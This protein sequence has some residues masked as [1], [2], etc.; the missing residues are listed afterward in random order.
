MRA[1]TAGATRAAA[2]SPSQ[3]AASAATSPAREPAQAD[4]LGA[5]VAP[6]VGEDAGERRPAADLGVAIGAEDQHG[7][8]ARAAQHEAE[9]EERR[10]VG[11][12][13]VVEHQH[14]RAVLGQAREHVV[15]GGEQPVTCARIVRGRAARLAEEAVE[16]ARARAG[17]R[18]GRLRADVAQHLGEGLE[19]RQ[20]VLRAAAEQDGRAAVQR[21]PGEAQ[22]EAR[23]ADAR[24]ARQ[25]HEAAG[26]VGGDA[27]PG[28]REPRPLRA[29]AH[30]GILARTCEDG[31]RRDVR[32]RRR[33][34]RG[35]EPGQALLGAHEQRVQRGGGP[36]PA[37]GLGQV[38]GRLGR[39]RQPVERLGA[40]LGVGAP[41]LV[42]PLVVHVGQQDAVAGRVRPVDEAGGEQVGALAQVDARAVERDALARGHQAGGLGAERAAQLRQGRAQ[43]RAGALVEHLGP[44]PRR[45]RA[46]GVRS[47]VGG[48][49]GEQRA[50]A[51]GPRRR[52]LPA[53][54]LEPQ[55]P[56][57]ADA[58]HR[59]PP[60]P[61]PGRPAAGPDPH[62]GAVT[63]A[64]PR[65]AGAGAGAP[66]TG[67][68]ADHGRFTVA[69]RCPSGRG[70]HSGA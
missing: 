52:E 20:R 37:G 41:E 45:E 36:R 46:A 4:P 63:P 6:Q 29:A 61:R 51:A 66:A 62:H 23:L 26:P 8:R 10:P 47:R 22:R 25:E 3:V 57:E 33:A 59:R 7:R 30:E 55:A 32:R 42:H 12:V 9:Q 1:C 44:E 60:Y 40:A 11:P 65:A 31:R 50:G 67:P 16:L 68:C 2:S 15:D 5:A 48:E 54:G 56:G 19:R 24:L 18:P 13:Q 14:E 38:A 35:A 58:E 27:R 17:E 70:G 69:E 28:A 34:A 43:A 53:A 49:I 21:L 39:R 64:A